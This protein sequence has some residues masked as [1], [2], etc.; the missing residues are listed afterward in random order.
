MDASLAA[1]QWSYLICV[2]NTLKTG[3]F[4]ATGQSAPYFRLRRNILANIYCSA[5]NGNSSDDPLLP[6][7]DVSSQNSSRWGNPAVFFV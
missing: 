1:G 3:G 7:L 4:G 6:F 5:T 2:S